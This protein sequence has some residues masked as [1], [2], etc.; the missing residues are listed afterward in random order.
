MG[1][2]QYWFRKIATNDEGEDQ[3]EEIFYHRKF[4]ALEGFMARKWE[5]DHPGD[6]FN[7]EYLTVTSEVLDELEQAAQEDKLDPTAGFFFG[8]TEK[9]EW[10][11][12][13]LKELREKI[14]PFVRKEI[15]AGETILYS[16]WW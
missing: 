4:N 3:H 1:L 5:A 12:N 10:Y 6:T 15:E 14:I 16:S 13:D 8:G 7:C 9:D 11:L 2:D